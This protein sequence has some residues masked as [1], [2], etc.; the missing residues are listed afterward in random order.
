MNIGI[1]DSGIIS[2]DCSL[3]EA[4]DGFCHI[5]D[6]GQVTDKKSH[7][8]SGHG[9]FNASILVGKS[10][11]SINSMSPDAR[12]FVAAAIEGQTLVLKVLEALEW[13]LQQPIDI[14]LMPFGI[15]GESPVFSIHI[16]ALIEKG[17]LPI[18]AIGNEGAGKFRSPGCYSNVLSVGA[19]D[20]DG[21][22]AP[23]SGSLNEKDSL[24][25]IKPDVGTWGV[26]VESPYQKIGKQNG[27]SMAATILT[28]HTSNLWQKY[29]SFTNQ[30][31]AQLIC[32]AITPLE[33]GQRH[34][35]KHGV[36]DHKKAEEII[37][38]EG[39]EQNEYL[40]PVIFER[41]IDPYLKTRCRYYGDKRVEFILIPKK[42]SSIESILNQFESTQFIKSYCDNLLILASAEPSDIL[43][44]MDYE[45]VK[46]L[47]YTSV[48]FLSL[49]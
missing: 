2:D 49:G 8:P 13:M 31:L 30:Q 4:L 21:I 34:R 20:Q 24:N 23:F 32:K 16:Q 48:P 29:P 12:L 41:Y 42:D 45:E 39:L 5:N 28:G 40:S 6:S 47:Q 9:T 35:C 14:L 26:E 25:C 17:V 18:A 10:E 27:S 44:L 46:L 11:G 3:S 33:E 22:I 38:M 37:E 1:I 19:C 36:F 15:K 43:Q 7:D